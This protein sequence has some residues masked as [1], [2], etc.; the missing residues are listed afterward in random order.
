MGKVSAERFKTK[1]C[2]NYIE[3]GACPYVFRCMFAH[4]EHE[5]RTKQM[6]MADGLVTEEAIR[7]FKR[8]VYDT[9]RRLYL[10]SLSTTH[11]E[12]HTGRRRNDPY[13]V[14]STWH[15]FSRFDAPSLFAPIGSDARSVHEGDAEAAAFIAATFKRAAVPASPASSTASYRASATPSPVPAMSCSSC[16]ASVANAAV[17]A[18]LC[19][20]PSVS[21]SDSCHSDDE[22]MASP[23]I[24]CAAAAV[25]TLESQG[26]WVMARC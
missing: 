20:T 5:L 14:C 12:A 6:N 1:M 11:V 3:Q 7:A 9:K 13:A 25:P 17:N 19:A 15:P 4:G 16:A 10:A 21:S 8:A 18:V 26:S 22:A 24:S 2:Q 23:I